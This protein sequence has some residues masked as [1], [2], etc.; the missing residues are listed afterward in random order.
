MNEKMNF[1]GIK[2]EFGFFFFSKKN[3]LCFVCTS[4]LWGR[5][6]LFYLIL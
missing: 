2:L 4:S 6:F 1:I 3:E 5:A